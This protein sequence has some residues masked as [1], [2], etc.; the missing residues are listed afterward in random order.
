[1]LAGIIF[2]VTVGCGATYVPPPAPDVVDMEATH[3]DLLYGAGT[4]SHPTASQTGWQFDIPTAPGSVHYVEVP[5]T[6]TKGLAGKTFSVTFRMV[7]NKPVYNANV[8]PGESGPATFHLFFEHL[9]DNFTNQYYRWWCDS[10]G[11][12]LGTQ[13]NQTVTLSCPLTYTSWLSV[14]GLRDE[15]KF[16]D[17]LKHIGWVGVT[18]GSADML[19]HG[20]NLLGGS[21]QF[22]VL[23]MQIE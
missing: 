5:F 18:F 12:T 15:A 1:M 7:S 13:D 8:E 3:W 4:P 17:T 14:Y 16:A 21:A 20:V 19:G 10:V 2:I 9:N 11:Y 6:A 23:E 22:Q